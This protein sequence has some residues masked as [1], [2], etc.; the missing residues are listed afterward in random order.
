MP[1]RD[2][3]YK[4]AYR[5]GFNGKEMD[6]EPYGQGNEYDYGMRIYNPRIG[7]F[8]SVDPLSESYPWYSPYQYAGNSPIAN[9]DIDG[10]EPKPSTN[11]TYEGQSM[12]T[13]E[14]FAQPSAA[15]HGSVMVEK[16]KTWFWHAGNS[17]YGTSAGWYSSEDYTKLLTPIAR[18]LAGYKGLFSPAA[19]N[20]MTGH[21]W[22]EAEQAN[23][24][25]TKLGRFIGTGLSEDAANHLAASVYNYSVG[26]NFAVSGFTEPSTVNSEDILV[27]PTLVRTAIK[28]ISSAFIEASAKLMTRQSI[29]SKLT[30]YILNMDHP[31]GGSK[32]KW[33]K[34]A[35]G[36]TNNDAD[37]LAKQLEFDRN[38]ATF[39]GNNGFSDLYEQFHTIQGKNGRVINVQFNWEIRNG[40]NFHRLV[41]AIPTK[42]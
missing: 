33:F 16:A 38:K 6:N 42:R 19:N 25:N 39:I 14:T 37:F 8:L 7:R 26:R 20:S 23:I 29:D 40:E 27:I 12:T 4:T 2:T 1:G 21:N 30:R 5:Y 22:T 28:T 3:T 9:V 36:I 35:L 11:G 15:A 41:G 32:A 18:D 24:A 34:E 31:I 17:D 10:G 13:S